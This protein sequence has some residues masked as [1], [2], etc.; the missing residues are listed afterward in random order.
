VADEQVI[1]DVIVK[2]QD[3]ARGLLDQ[4]V[5][6]L[7]QLS[8]GISTMVSHQQRSAQAAAAAA[9]AHQNTGDSLDR[10]I[11]LYDGLTRNQ[12]RAVKGFEAM[13]VSL[14]AGGRLNQVQASWL[15]SLGTAVQQN[16]GFMQQHGQAWNAFIAQAKVGTQITPQMTQQLNQLGQQFQA[17][18]VAAHNKVNALQ[19]VGAAASAASAILG[20]MA[21]VALHGLIGALKES[22]NQAA[23]FQ[24][25]F[26]GLST[27]ARSFGQDIAA[28]NAAARALS[29]DGLLTVRDAAA[30]LKNLLS[31]GF[32]LQEAINLMNGF[33]DTAA[34]GR[35]AS[36]EFG[37]AIVS[38]TE[39]IKNQNSLLVD[40]A[41]LTKNLTI[42]LKERG[43]SEQDLAKVQTDATVRMALYNGLLKEMAVSQGDAARMADTYSGAVTALN[44]QMSFLQAAIGEKLL[45]LFQPFI[46]ALA[47]VA[48]WLR[49][50]DS[51]LA[52]QARILG[53]VAAVAVTLT[54]ALTALLGIAG[55]VAG[56]ISTLGTAL[57]ALNVSMG[58]IK[59]AL[60]GATGLIGLLSLLV[61]GLVAWKL[62]TG[63]NTDALQANADALQRQRDHILTARNELVRLKETGAD[64]T[65]IQNALIRTFVELGNTVPGVTS[66]FENLDLTISALTKKAQGLGEELS[67]VVMVDLEQKL[68][69]WG[70]SAQEQSEALG[71]LIFQIAK[72][73][74]DIGRAD[75]STLA[76]AN[77]VEVWGR[78]RNEMMAQRREL[79]AL[80]DK[81]NA[82][83]EQQKGMSAVDQEAAR[84]RQKLAEV[85]RRYGELIKGQ[86]TTRKE[87]EAAEKKLQENLDILVQK[88]MNRDAAMRLPEMVKQAKELTSAAREGVAPMNDLALAIQRRGE[89]LERQRRLEQEA[90]E[91]AREQANRIRALTRAH[92]DATEGVDKLS[93]RSELLRIVMGKTNTTFDSSLEALRPF[94]AL[95][96]EIVTRVEELGEKAPPNIDKLKQALN[97]L[98][99]DSPFD[100]AHTANLEIA[101]RQASEF[102][103]SMAQLRSE[104][105]EA[106]KKQAEDTYNKI[107]AIQAQQLEESFR[108]E[109]DSLAKREAEVRRSFD[110][111]VKDLDRYTADGER[112][113]N[114]HFNFLQERIKQLGITW[115]REF[116]GPNKIEL[117]RLAAEAK[118]R[119]EDMRDSG[120][121]TATQVNAA[122][123]D[124]YEK[125]K[126]A[127]TSNA[128]VFER[129][130]DRAL[131][132]V[133]EFAEQIA[134]ISGNGEDGFSGAVKWIGTIASSMVQASKA[135]AS[136]TR[137]MAA[138]KDGQIAQ[139]VSDTAEAAMQTVSAFKAA[140]NSASR[141]K[142]ALGGAAVGAKIG[143]N[144]AL[145]AATGGMSVVAGA[146]I[147]AVAGAFRM[148]E[149][150]KIQK[151]VG[152]DLGFTI[153]K[154][155]ATSIGD[156]KKNLN[157]SRDSAIAL[158]L[159]GII[160]ESGGA[161]K[162]YGTQIDDLFKLTRGSTK[163]AQTAVAE[164]NN[165]FGI[166]VQNMHDK[167]NGL[168]DKGMLD[169]IKRTKESGVEVKAV[170]DFLKAMADNAAGALNRVV[171][172]MIGQSL[173]NMA[174]VKDLVNKQIPDLLKKDKEL[175]DKIAGERDPGALRAMNRELIEIQEQLKKAFSEADR[176]SASVQKFAES[177]QEGFDRMGRLIS[178]TFA[179]GLASGKTFI[180]ML[181]NIAPSLDIMKGAAEEF[182]F[183]ID[184][185]FADLLNLSDFAAMNG[186]L[187]D[188]VDAMNQ[189]TK[190]LHN[191]GGLSQET[192]GDIGATLVD[193][194][195]QLLDAGATGDQAWQM[196][197]PS[198]QTL[199]E[200]KQRF[201]YAVDEATGKLLE[202]AEAAGRV[203]EK[204]ASATERMVAGV[205]KMV[206]RMERLLTHFG[207]DFPREAEN[208]GTTAADAM[209]DAASSVQDVTT[210]IY[211]GVEAWRAWGEAAYAAG[212]QGYE[213]TLSTVYGNSPGG[214]VDVQ[215]KLH[216]LK[217][218]WQD[219]KNVI[220]NALSTESLDKFIAAL[221]ETSH[222]LERYVMSDVGRQLD[223]I[224]Q[225][226]RQS[227][228]K[229]LKDM[230]GATQEM[231]DAGVEAINKLAELQSRDLVWEDRHRRTREALEEQN[232]LLEEQKRIQD[233]AAESARRW[234]ATIR[235]LTEELALENTED[236]LEKRLLELQFRHQRDMEEFQKT[237]EGASRDQ[238]ESGLRM[239]E[240]LYRKRREKIIEE[241]KKETEVQEEVVRQQTVRSASR[242]I[243]GTMGWA[244]ADPS[245]GGA[246][247]AAVAQALQL[248]LRGGAV[249]PGGRLEIV[250]PIG[251][252]L[253]RVIVD[254]TKDAARNRVL[255]MD[256]SA[257][258]NRLS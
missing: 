108:N 185:A 144:P 65:Q 242:D 121:Y 216:E 122:W 243:L 203:G 209:T 245:R 211:A 169:F 148:P 51:A 19:N 104:R 63:E 153:S 112:L 43:L 88:G 101:K 205:D 126:A 110:Q 139:G 232:R 79:E 167:M 40:N 181:R 119:F 77:S 164:L 255:Q 89:A 177:G 179:S 32:G 61:G 246:S 64:A 1:L 124:S 253:Q 145:M 16:T 13:N 86:I 225:R 22:V 35:Q 66:N 114:A 151:Q 198:L 15:Q 233:E 125:Q 166:M 38:A 84:S 160:K 5:K 230:E 117:Q 184:G 188:G 34:F 55:A 31:A 95:I 130:M 41:G 224:E 36:L 56:A 14:Q 176:L 18:T 219:Q 136:L 165:V 249:V 215:E 58:A 2:A 256:S 12:A 129:N 120:E 91:H 157:V 195:Q 115:K 109:H 74:R 222:G 100:K 10:L 107:Q 137:G 175:R 103:K 197:Q 238:M 48:E 20:G 220:R 39:G 212:Q 85:E 54:A 83:I 143:A 183:T 207:V 218:Q 52:D 106:D 116:Y 250:I 70:S 194:R 247:A 33:K 217:G 92:D 173:Q 94:Q 21:A 105:A 3:Q 258:R 248:A 60:I 147:G 229:F 213:G 26:I 162:D 227:I 113:Y 241:G 244:Q 146:I 156:L 192:F 44:V 154:E 99:E 49:T 142:N 214:L 178:V 17:T 27:V 202:E 200:L 180:E 25:T 191:M 140:T 187:I 11:R 251:K 254:L 75:I 131:A 237:M 196:M 30:G 59:V 4:Q 69:K 6:L 172:G 182:G 186:L 29:S 210:D 150:A 67:K 127:S 24:N 174:M 161:L 97:R 98:G 28:T 93:N 82:L 68:S 8:S 111:S 118:K 53:V 236:P 123:I 163:V 189:L 231:I 204:H 199:W 221:A 235:D 234:S 226:R 138:F 46:K 193:M 87:Y 208:S 239:L 171:G 80:I 134:Q 149:W 228:T 206:D 37:Y 81:R 133:A 257:V 90:A 135:G 132:G 190:S 73:E 102:N 76:G 50:N 57:I 23:L 9:K 78:A 240:E 128:D 141:W 72:L 155:L 201:G 158:S 47:T 152:Q 62:G 45:P 71:E 7:Q 96:R 223:D 252:R 168:A 159:S 170:N 42:I